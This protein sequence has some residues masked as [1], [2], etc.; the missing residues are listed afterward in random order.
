MCWWQC[1]ST[2]GGRGQ[3]RWEV[4]WWH[5]MLVLLCV[6]CVV[7]CVLCVLCCVLCV[8]CCVLCVVLCLLA[9]LIN[10]ANQLVEIDQGIVQI[11]KLCSTVNKKSSQKHPDFIRCA[12][13]EWFIQVAHNLT[14]KWELYCGNKKMEQKLYSEE[15][16]LARYST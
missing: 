15:Q 9:N 8:V 4:G 16:N 14:L 12:S 7:C 1:W 5:L 6:L 11:S 2:H 10:L 13:V 3:S